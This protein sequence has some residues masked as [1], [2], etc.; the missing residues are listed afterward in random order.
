MRIVNPGYEILTPIDRDEILTAIEIAGRTC[1]K[2]EDKI[3]ADSAAEF[4]KMI[5]NRGHFSVLEHRIISV[6][7]TVDRG[8][9]HEIVRHRIA[10]FSQESTRYCNYNRGKFGSELSII[11]IA[12]HLK[13]FEN[14][15]QIRD[16]WVDAMQSAEKHYNKMIELGASPQIAR[17]VLPNSL[18][19][20]IVVTANMR[21]WREI[22]RQRTAPAAHPQIREVMKPLQAELQLKLPEVFC[23]LGEV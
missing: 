15:L 21:E 16:A 18:K 7:F 3:T 20:E 23:T 1:Y 8:I 4:V 19:A 13:G 12:P 22:F 11:D 6:K 9:T 10:S 17:S 2:S 5:V 14:D